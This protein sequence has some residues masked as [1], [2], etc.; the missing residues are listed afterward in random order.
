ME[1][2][3]ITEPFLMPE[4]IPIGKLTRIETRTAAKV[5]RPVAGSRLKISSEQE[6]LKKM[7]VPK[8]PCKTP[9]I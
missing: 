7:E 2:K 6:R 9:P 4:M 3:S 1:I 5:N 8:S